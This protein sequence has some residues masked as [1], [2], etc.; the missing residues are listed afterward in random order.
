[1]IQEGNLL[2]IDMENEGFIN[3]YT[4]MIEDEDL[5]HL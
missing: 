1:M 2:N 4:C 5:T 3:E